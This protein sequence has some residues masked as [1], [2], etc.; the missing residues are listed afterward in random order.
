LGTNSARMPAE[1]DAITD[2]A[3]LG[4]RLR[5]LQPRRGHRFG[6]DAILLA[7]STPGGAGEHAIDLGAGVGTAGLA[8]A[9]RVAGLRVMLVDIDHAL[10]KLAAENI[11]R[12]DLA[13]RARAIALD[14][15]APAHECA[16]A[17]LELGTADRVLMNPPFN[18]SD[19]TQASPDEQRRAAH[20]ASRDALAAWVRT[21]HEMLRPG[22]T[23]SLIYR[24]D[25]RDDVIA[26]LDGIF[27]AVMVMPVFPRPNA[28]PIRI[29]VCAEKG[30]EA[31]LEERAGLILND[32]EGRPT[33]EAEAV[34]RAGAPLAV[35]RTT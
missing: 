34:L 14:V 12:N 13:D 8:L 11:A 27:G 23:L 1:A 29:L 28:A 24:A 5:L 17:G 10:V 9:R 25:A 2:D 32:E 4:G 22:A 20:T 7:A 30:S 16:S 35:A 18:D 19:R 21:A 26:A 31:S 15:T 6:H 33:A 3:V